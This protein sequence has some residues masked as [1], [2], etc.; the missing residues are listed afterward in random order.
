MILFR[1][2][3]KATVNIA[4]GAASQRVQVANQEGRLQVRV[5]NDGSAT[6]WISFGDNTVT[7]DAT[8]DIPVGA[9]ETDGFTVDAPSGS[10]IYAAV[11]AAGSTGNVYFTPGTGI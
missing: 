2:A 9:G 6:V 7:A 11:I 5:K 4:A 1:A 10:P 3:S 8:K